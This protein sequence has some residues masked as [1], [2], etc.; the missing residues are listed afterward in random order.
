[1]TEQQDTGNCK[2][3]RFIIGIVHH[4]LS[5]CTITGSHIGTAIV[6]TL[7]LSKSVT[8]KNTL[9][10]YHRDARIKEDTVN[11]ACSKLHKKFISKSG[12]STQ[13]RI[14]SVHSKTENN[15]YPQKQ[16]QTRR[17]KGPAVAMEKK[18][19]GPWCKTHKS[20][21][22]IPC[23]SVLSRTKSIK[24]VNGLHQPIT[25]VLFHTNASVRQNTIVTCM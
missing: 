6:T 19:A 5:G 11:W 21:H 23:Q 9:I 3:R 24:D 1:V 14:R 8:S 20:V 25:L 7:Q 17:T 18:L 13:Y 12:Q 16:M 22:Y 2:M 4:T 10:F 15:I